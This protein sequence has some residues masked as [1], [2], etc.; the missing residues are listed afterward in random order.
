ML[1]SANYNTASVNITKSVTIL[2]VPGAVGSVVATGGNAININTAGVKVALRNL[3]LVPL[4]G[5]GGF[6]GISMTDGASLTVE[7]CL[8]ANL[9]GTGI[10][11]TGAASV[12]I[13]DTTIRGNA[14]SGLYF[15]NGASATVTR[16]IVSA[17]GVFGI[18]VLGD[19]SST[20]M[21]DIADSTLAGNSQGIVVGANTATSTTKSL[22]QGQSLREK[23][24]QRHHRAIHRR[25][26][27]HAVREQQRRLEQ[28]RLRNPVQLPG[29][30][31][32]GERQYRERQPLRARQRRCHLRNR[33]RQRGSQQRDCGHLGDHHGHHHEVR[34]PDADFVQDRAPRRRRPGNTEA[35]SARRS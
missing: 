7:G 1:D 28:R 22:R 5:A 35:R 16:A 19:G 15:T 4:P 18:G 30:Q 26:S 10:F 8:L 27:H 34:P 12:H 33:G 2:A 13:S 29:R 23:H 31:G 32:L 20:T 17:N 14:G 9:P 11:V 3:V 25:R 24:G 21:A 6:N